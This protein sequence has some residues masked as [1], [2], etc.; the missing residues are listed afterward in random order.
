MNTSRREFFGA[1]SGGAALMLASL[2]LPALA[3]EGARGVQAHAAQ[4]PHRPVPALK[5][6]DKVA[7]VAPSSPSSD[8][9]KAAEWL[10][11]H[12]FS[13]EIMP[14]AMEKLAPPFDYLAGTDSARVDD[15]HYAFLSNE[16]K[17]VWC[18]RGGFGATRLL[19][20]LDY[21]LIG[22]NP[23]PFIGYSDI[24]ALHIAL[25]QHAGMVTFHG[26]MLVSDL[27]PEKLPP[28][29]SLILDL[30]SGRLSSGAWIPSPP[31]YPAATLV[32]GTAQG[33]L[34]G[35][36]LSLL[37]STLGTPYE[38]D[39]TDAILFI[40][41]TE[42]ALPRLDRLLTQLRLAGKLR[43]IRG[44]LLGRFVIAG[45]TPAATPSSM[46][47][48]LFNEFFLPLKIP[49]MVNWSSGHVDPNLA[50]P[51]GATVLLDTAQGAIR[52]LSEA[53]V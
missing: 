21:A 39:S 28:T 10:R 45:E 17:A 3:R 52:L 51:L 34:V 19:D 20:K 29:A 4:G 27:V 5:A 18:L 13:V 40:E 38:M 15:I 24:T 43:S 37:C 53:V 9:E 16:I 23:K 30:L 25:Q 11:A 44:L 2:G 42:I 36:N 35:G 46:A 48:A 50:L 47:N 8:V 49:V 1:A 26:P 22:A 12:G 7:I 14:S 32:D 41:D 33:R 6:G 31:M